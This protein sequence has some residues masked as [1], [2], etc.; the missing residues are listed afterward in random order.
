MKL[1]V[2][3]LLALCLQRAA[4]S[5]TSP[6]P[7]WSGG[8][9]TSDGILSDI[10]P[11]NDTVTLLVRADA[12]GD[13]EMGGMDDDQDDIR[14]GPPRSPSPATYPVLPALTD[15]AAQQLAQKGAKLYVW[16]SEPNSERLEQLLRQDNKLCGGH[17]LQSSFTDYP[18]DLK[19][20]GWVMNAL[21]RDQH[22]NQFRYGCTTEAD[23][24]WSW[25]VV[26]LG[27]PAHSRGRQRVCDLEP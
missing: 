1:T 5:P 14:Q 12:S 11:S 15:A 10:A 13:V 3:Y 20:A 25:S 17:S 24:E 2:A 7:Q 4:P 18:R 21:G 16:M 27:Y 19:D 9:T 23:G 8:L 26:F 22:R 6:Q